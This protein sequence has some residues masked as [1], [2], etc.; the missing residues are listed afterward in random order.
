MGHCKFKAGRMRSIR[1]ALNVL[2]VGG[3]VY[4]IS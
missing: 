3:T 2:T 4:T 1:P